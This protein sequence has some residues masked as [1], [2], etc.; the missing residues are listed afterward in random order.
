V[1]GC[2]YDRTRATH[3]E[4]TEQPNEDTPGGRQTGQSLCLGN[5]LGRTGRR[6][7]YAELKAAVPERQIKLDMHDVAPAW[8]DRNLV[9]QVFINLIS[10]AIKF[11]GERDIG[12]IEI[13]CETKDDV[14]VYGVKDNG[15][16]FEMQY[17]DKLFGVFQRLHSDE[18][19][20]GTGIGLALVQRIIHRHGGRIW[21]E[22][23]PGKGAT[24]HFTLPR[25][26]RS[27]ENEQSENKEP[28]EAEWC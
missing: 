7:G 3:H 4:Y 20:E 12:E 5:A 15:A 19:F 26:G 6:A 2:I 1:Y 28:V 11:T 17:A 10:N 25:L 23:E 8:G 22:G 16:G 18:Q 9:Q 24:F 21:A 14:N 13:W 27:A